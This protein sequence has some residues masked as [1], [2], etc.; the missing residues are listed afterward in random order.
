M[1]RKQINQRR[2]KI[3]SDG[4]TLGGRATVGPRLGAGAGQR[5]GTGLGG[6]HTWGQVFLGGP[7][8]GRQP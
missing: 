4:G 3:S 6:G 5:L 2:S 7:S 1:S 8:E